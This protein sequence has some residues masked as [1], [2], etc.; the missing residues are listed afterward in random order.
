MGE[1]VGE[2]GDEGS[3]WCYAE[4]NMTTA[5]KF[6]DY[7][8]AELERVADAFVAEFGPRL[9]DHL[10]TTA[11]TERVL[12]W[13][14][15]TKAD[16][17]TTDARPARDRRSRNT[18]GEFLFDL[19]HSTWP[20]YGEAWGTKAYW[21]RALAGQPPELLL[22]LESEW[23]HARN[24]ETNLHKVLED[25]SK[26]LHVRARAKVMLFASNSAANRDEIHGLL[27]RLI[28]ADRTG[29]CTWL[30][31]D[32]PWDVKLDPKKWLLSVLPTPPAT[33]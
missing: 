22:A 4:V 21:D 17:A 8:G 28:A 24:A 16:F 20:S 32:M 13:I 27:T 10:A 30:L 5:S 2:R 26:L 29:L 7:S 9:G 11:W 1:D 12:D 6:L 14:E 23:G 31:I 3:T 19:V 33:T 25:A 15:K 18:G